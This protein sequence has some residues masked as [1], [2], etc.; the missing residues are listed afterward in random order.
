MS[1]GDERE[2]EGG[3][4]CLCGCGG[5]EGLVGG[6]LV[7]SSSSIVAWVLCTW[8]NYRLCQQWPALMTKLWPSFWLCV[9][10]GSKEGDRLLCQRTASAARGRLDSRCRPFE[11]SPICVFC[12]R[13]CAVVCVQCCVH[14]AVC[15]QTRSW[16]Q[17]CHL[18]MCTLQTYSVVCI[19]RCQVCCQE[20]VCGPPQRPSTCVQASAYCCTIFALCY[21]TLC[22]ACQAPVH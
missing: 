21:W 14:T 9:L 3:G 10:Q 7:G 11:T 2:R 19:Q 12:I 20:N 13:Y 1:A 5:L 16:Q 4:R 15:V 18:C 22:P 17:T 8:R 6:C